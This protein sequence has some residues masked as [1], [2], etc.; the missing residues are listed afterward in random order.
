MLFVP[1]M[2]FIMPE[3]AGKELFEI[4]EEFTKGKCWYPCSCLMEKPAKVDDG[5]I[6]EMEKLHP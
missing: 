3:T 2:F 5:E 4:Q 1:I 6:I